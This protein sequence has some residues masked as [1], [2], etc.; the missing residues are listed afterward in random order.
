[1]NYNVLR[2][3]CL[4]LKA[5][6]INNDKFLTIR[7]LLL[8]SKLLNVIS[9]MFWLLMFEKNM[10]LYCQIVDKYIQNGIFPLWSY[11]SICISFHFVLHLHTDPFLFRAS[12]KKFE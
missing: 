2:K 6:Y 1:M 4:I 8:D 12:E 7:I 5:W 10:F 11:F 9:G 3:C